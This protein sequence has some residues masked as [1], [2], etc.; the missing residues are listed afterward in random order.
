M[1]CIYIYPTNKHIKIKI[2]Y[3][4]N[5]IDKN[6]RRLRVRKSP[7]TST[8]NVPSASYVS[9]KLQLSLCAIMAS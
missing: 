2:K 1:S 6:V 3:I 4:Y 5:Y 8:C 7:E 9:I